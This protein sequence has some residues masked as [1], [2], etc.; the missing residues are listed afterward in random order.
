[1]SSVARPC[2][3]VDPSIQGDTCSAP[4]DFTVTSEFRTVRRK[5]NL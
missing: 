1:M 4:F 2:A 3:F 5:T